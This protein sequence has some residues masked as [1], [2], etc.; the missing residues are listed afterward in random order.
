ME[1]KIII[2]GDEPPDIAI[3][4]EPMT[5]DQI[6]SYVRQA[7]HFLLVEVPGSGGQYKGFYRSG[8]GLGQTPELGTDQEAAIQAFREYLH[9]PI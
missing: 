3:L 8:N 7:Q 5:W 4:I 2:N 9:Q 1:P 6:E